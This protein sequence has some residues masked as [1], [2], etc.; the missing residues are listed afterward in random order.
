[1][2]S[3]RKNLLMNLRKEKKL[4]TDALPSTDDAGVTDAHDTLETY[5]TGTLD[6]SIDFLTTASVNDI[7]AVLPTLQKQHADIDLP[8][9][10]EN[11]CRHSPKKK[12]DDISR[13]HEEVSYYL[14]AIKGKLLGGKRASKRRRRHSNRARSKRRR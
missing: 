12:C 13:V 4:L 3:L 14:D 5:I 8:S 10:F 6:L 1:M 2:D 7:E 9:Y 11:I